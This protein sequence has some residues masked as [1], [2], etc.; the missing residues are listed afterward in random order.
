MQ[1]ILIS[2]YN[3]NNK[4]HFNFYLINR[5]ILILLNYNNSNLYKENHKFS[6]FLNLV[7]VTD[8]NCFS[9]SLLRKFLPKQIKMNF[10]RKLALI[11]LTKIKIMNQIINLSVIWNLSNLQA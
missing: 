2:I 4:T 6:N 5:K 7:G 10:K 1:L 11:I 8:W 9:F 3:N